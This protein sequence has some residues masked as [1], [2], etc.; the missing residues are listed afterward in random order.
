[1]ARTETPALF[2][3]LFPHPHSQYPHT[4]RTTGGG[5]PRIQG[6]EGLLTVLLLRRRARPSSDRGP[7][8]P[9]PPSPSCVQTRRGA[10]KIEWAVRGVEVGGGQGTGGPTA[11]AESLIGRREVAAEACVGAGPS[12]QTRRSTNHRDRSAACLDFHKKRWRRS[13]GP[14]ERAGRETEK[15]GLSWKMRVRLRGE[16]DSMGLTEPGPESLRRP[17]RPL[18][19]RQSRR[20]E[21]NSFALG[22]FGRG[23]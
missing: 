19:S 5:S 11:A 20:G 23:L 17:G 14:G 18:A 22:R 6:L 3:G 2:S 9:P 16:R 12:R 15:P 10:A 4:S 1:M 7:P 8:R 21:G 13:A